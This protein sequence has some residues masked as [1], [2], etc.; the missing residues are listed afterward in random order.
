MAG[1]VRSLMTAKMARPTSTRTMK[2]SSMKPMTGHRPMT[3]MANSWEMNTAPTV[4]MIVR[5]RTMK[6]HIAN[7]CAVP[8]T[9]HFSSFFCPST[10]VACVSKAA[11]RLS[12]R[13]TVGC[14]EV[15]NLNSVQARRPATASTAMTSSP[16]TIHRMV[17]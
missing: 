13:S 6:P 7:T 17:M 15:I 14:P 10:S 11:G 3:G 4:S 16:P 9:V 2:T 5:I 1:W 12:G 8:G